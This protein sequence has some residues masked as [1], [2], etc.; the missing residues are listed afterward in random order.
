M[1]DVILSAKEEIMK[2]NRGVVLLSGGIDST[3]TL[4]IAFDEEYEISVLSFSYGQRHSIE[5]ECAKKIVKFFSLKTHV[6]IDIPSHIFSS[7]SLVEKSGISIPLNEDPSR[8]NVIPSTY[9]PAR[10]ILFLSYALAYAESINAATIFIGANILDYSGYPDCR[11]EFIAAFETMANLGTRTGVEGNGFVI[12]APLLQLT[13]SNIIK[14]GIELGIDYA[15]TI[16]CYS[17]KGDGHAC[18]ECDSCIIRKK[19]FVEANIPDPTRYA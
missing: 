3:T 4:A 8:R 13:K 9:V 7:S 10:N 5:I 17:P 15:M 18:G 19:G 14:R 11:P 1:Q 16:S 6:I 12:K 2:N